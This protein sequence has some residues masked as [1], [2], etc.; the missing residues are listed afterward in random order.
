[1]NKFIHGVIFGLVLAAIVYS[2]HSGVT[3]IVD[4]NVSSAQ[5]CLKDKSK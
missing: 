2:G 5:H 4:T 1:M 3:H